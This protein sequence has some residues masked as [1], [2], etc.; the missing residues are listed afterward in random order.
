[1]LGAASELADK[2]VGRAPVGRAKEGLTPSSSAA[3]LAFVV[4]GYE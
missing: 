1:M 3:S 4:M 2:V